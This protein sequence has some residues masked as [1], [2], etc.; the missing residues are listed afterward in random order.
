MAITGSG[1]TE[2]ARSSG[3]D[4]VEGVYVHS[5]GGA[6]SIGCATKADALTQSQTLIAVL[7]TA[8]GSLK[9]VGAQGAVAQIM[10]EFRM[11]KRRARASSREDQEVLHEL[12]RQR[13]A[14]LALERQRRLLLQEEKKRAQ[15]AAKLNA[16]AK[17]ATG[18]LKERK[19]EIENAEDVPEANHAVK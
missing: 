13:D 12:E 15:T 19:R 1:D 16:E 10:D 3:Y 2:D 17:A 4:D 14:E 5:C 18:R 8:M 6:P 9:Q 7:E 11:E